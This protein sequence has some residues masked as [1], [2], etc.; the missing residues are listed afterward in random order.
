MINAHLKLSHIHYRIVETFQIVG[1]C[2]IPVT[3][4]PL[5]GRI[6]LYSLSPRSI[7]SWVVFQYAKTGCPIPLV[8]YLPVQ[9]YSFAMKIPSR[10]YYLTVPPS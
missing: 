4:M 5:S 10:F 6:V 8:G 9:G 7:P 1:D 3:F 2:D